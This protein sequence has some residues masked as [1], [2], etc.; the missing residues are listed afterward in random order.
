MNPNIVNI[1]L[2]YE[3]TDRA[4]NAGILVRK[5]NTNELSYYIEN[6]DDT[7]ETV[8]REYAGMHSVIC[9]TI[10]EP[11]TW[12]Y[13]KPFEVLTGY[14]H[15]FH[16]PRIWLY[17]NKPHIS[18]GYYP[19]VL[20]GEY[21]V[22]RKK[23]NSCVHL[24]IGK[25]HPNG[26]EKNWGFFEHDN[27]LSIV[28]YPQPLIIVQ[29][30]FNTIG[31]NLVN[32]S[33]SVCNELG[34]GVCG[35]S[36]PVLHP[37]ENIYYMFVHKTII[38]NNYNIWCV[39]FTKIN[40]KDWRVKGFTK[41]RINGGNEAEISYAEGAVYDKRNNSWIISGGYRDI[42]LAFWTISHEELTSKMTWVF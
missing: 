22:E 11:Y 33:E 20:F 16:D 29:Y 19:M 27:L 9:G 18:F 30:N 8:Y 31:N 32:V 15:N 36:P 26:L 2:I 3:G 40:D 37:T 14:H 17:N 39:A 21:D 28:Y 10:I 6:D 25:N 34:I 35:G 42:N 12:K 13:S 24:P 23:I 7:L 1:E 5:H 41:E 38:K 4:M